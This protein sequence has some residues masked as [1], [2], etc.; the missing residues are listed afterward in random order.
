MSNNRDSNQHADD[1]KRIIVGLEVFAGLNFEQL[2]EYY[3]SH[4]EDKLCDVAPV[5][6]KGF[7]PCTRDAIRAIVSIAE[8]H[9]AQQA[10]PNDYSITD[11]AEAIRGRIV[12]L[13]VEEA[14]E[15]AVLRRVLEEATE[16]VRKTH[17]ERIFDFPCVL[18]SARKPERVSIGP[19]EFAP[20]AAF[21]ES[22][23]D[24]FREYVGSVSDPESGEARL[25]R[26]EMYATAYGWMASVRIPPC[27][28]RN[29]QA[30]AETVSATAI[31]LIRMFL[32][33]EHARDMRLAHSL[34]SS[35][36]NYEFVVEADAKLDIWATRKMPGA[37]VGDAWWDV[38]RARAPVFWSQAARL[39]EAATREQMSE[40][41]S[42]MVDSLSW[43]GEA[44][45]EAS[46]GKQIAQCEAALERLTV[47]G[48]FGLHAFCART[49]L[50]ARDGAEDD[51]EKCYWK[52][53]EIHVARSEVVHG[54][55]SA[56]SPVFQKSLR[57]A[58]DMTR[59]VLFRG[60]EMQ[61]HLD[62]GRIPST[63]KSLDDFY[64]KQMSPHANLFS[65]LRKEL[66]AKHDLPR[67]SKGSDERA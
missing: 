67:K 1:L 5:D 35:P 63:R 65:R 46:L 52:A 44:N 40:M 61:A 12:R 13:I 57:I 23:Q 4:E 33:A 50:L 49:A 16:E 45:F 2:R 41:A 3:A 56:G 17:I 11:L 51:L 7:L 39:L 66:N 42:R 54:I 58:L 31:H 30:R 18:V 24:G 37:I 32:G 8:R 48:R 6:G 9:V 47:T 25:K 14:T 38:I 60:L 59:T 43:F 20:L 21:L 36:A 55:V 15:E 22:K 53:F 26:F 28:L 34:S 62:A 10:N 27:A 64:N 19:V 29:S